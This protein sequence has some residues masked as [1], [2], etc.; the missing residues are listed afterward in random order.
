MSNQNAGI[1]SLNINLTKLDRTAFHK[2]NKGTYADISVL[3]KDQPGQYGDDGMIV[4][5]LGKERRE[6]GEKG[7]ILGNAKWIVRPTGSAPAQAPATVM[8]DGSRK[9]ADADLGGDDGMDD[10]PFAQFERG[11]FLP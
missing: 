8:G 1:L 11:M 10:I 2:G 6:A 7:E 4:Q 5:S 9:A 3:M